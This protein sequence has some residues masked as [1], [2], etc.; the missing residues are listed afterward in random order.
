ME[1]FWEFLDTAAFV[2]KAVFLTLALAVVAEIASSMLMGYEHKPGSGFLPTMA[3]GCL[4]I[5]QAFWP[6]EGSG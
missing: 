5:L 4:A 3:G 6:E 1:K 2:V